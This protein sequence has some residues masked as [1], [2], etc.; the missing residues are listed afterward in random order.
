MSSSRPEAI[1][2]RQVEA[3]N[4][5]D[6]DGFCAC[7]SDDVVVVDGDGNEMLSGMEGFRERYRQQFAGD[8]TGEVVGR[9]SAGSWVVDH[10]IA[11]PGGQTLEGL[12]AY[13]VHGDSIDRVHFLF[14][15][16]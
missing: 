1:V 3:Y 8:A 15:L 13:R 2:E 14:D 5:H 6:L 11:R 9:V 4:A 12:V 10:E 16:G 7:Y